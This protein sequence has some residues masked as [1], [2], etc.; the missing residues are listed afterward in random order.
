MFPRPE[1]RRK[2]NAALI[3]GLSPVVTIIAVSIALASMMGVKPQQPAAAS[4]RV[5]TTF[6]IKCA[7]L[8]LSLNI[9]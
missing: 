9:R 1:Q 5:S 3:A 2:T 7:G 8:S 6:S 4:Q